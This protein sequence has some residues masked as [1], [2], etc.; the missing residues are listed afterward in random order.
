M[1][2]INIDAKKS[3]IKFYQINFNNMLKRII[4]LEQV[5]LIPEI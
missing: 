2:F 3:L 4:H 1:D 5:P